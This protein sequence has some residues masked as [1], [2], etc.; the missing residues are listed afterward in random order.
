MSE[1]LYEIKGL[2][3]A[4]FL[5]RPN[6]FIAKIKIDKEIKT[7]HVA[8]TGRLKEIF[9]EGREVLVTDNKPEN[10]LD[11]KLYGV[12]LGDEWVLINT[13][14]HSSISKKLIENGRLG[15][16]PKKVKA[17]V[18]YKDSRLDFLVDDNLYIEVKS[19]NLLLENECRFPDAPST[20][21]VKHLNELIELK[22][23]GFRAGI[24]IL[25]FRDG[26]CFRPHEIRDPLF[27]KTFFKA[28]DE[29]VEFFGIKVRFD[30]EKDVIVYKETID[31]CKG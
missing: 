20:R 2:K 17:E 1:I 12:N 9:I 27:A 29:G 11:Y 28:L 5:E 3:K 7:A 31:I 21:A 13:S 14:I 26:Q 30:S 16:T 25:A 18:K 8:D 6:R 4:I 15:F 22:K 23:E 19:S 10:K 24:L